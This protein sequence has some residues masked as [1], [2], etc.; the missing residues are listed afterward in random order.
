MGPAPAAQE[1]SPLI[2]GRIAMTDR[3]HLNVN[4]SMSFTAA[5]AGALKSLNLPA[6]AGGQ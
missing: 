4:G 1:C 2:D 5:F 6:P 3:G